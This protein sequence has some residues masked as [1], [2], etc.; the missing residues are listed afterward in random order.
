LVFSPNVP[1]G[2][3]FI[4]I[5]KEES[6]LDTILGPVTNIIDGDTFEMKVTRIGTHNKYKYN[7]EETVRI[8]DIN[9]P[10]LQAPGGR[11]SKDLL[12]RQLKGKEVQCY[13]KTRDSYGRVVAEVKVI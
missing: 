3:F 13:V 2:G 9:A 8:D 11:R 10:E 12:E 7:N 4:C 1:E 6:M 5:T